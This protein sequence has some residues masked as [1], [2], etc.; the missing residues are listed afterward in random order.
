MTRAIAL[1]VR[2]SLHRHRLAQIGLIALFW[3][4]GEA[5]VRLAGLPVPGGVVGLGLVLLVLAAGWVSPFSLRRGAEWFIAEMLLF[6]V[7]AVLAVTDHQEFL[8]LLGLKIAAVILAG[9]VSVMA[10]TALSVE[11]A[12]RWRTRHAGPSHE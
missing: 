2:R 3:L 10:V 6:F 5:I 7:P 4:A 1:S 9:T 8:G 11:A 12:Y